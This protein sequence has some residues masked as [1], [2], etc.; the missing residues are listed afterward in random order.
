M[1]I[2]AG[3]IERAFPGWPGFGECRRDQVAFEERRL[4]Q[5]RRAPDGQENSLRPG[6]GDQASCLRKPGSHAKLTVGLVDRVQ[7]IFKDKLFIDREGPV[8]A[9]T[10]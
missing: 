8:K 1:S 2:P 4:F 6:E 5:R 10:Q 9:L 3:I 7:K